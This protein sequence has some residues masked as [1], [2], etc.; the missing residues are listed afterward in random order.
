MQCTCHAALSVL[1]IEHCNATKHAIAYATPLAHL[2]CSCVQRPL[3]LF[4]TFASPEQSSTA[5][6]DTDNFQRS[7]AFKLSECAGATNDVLTSLVAA[8]DS[9]PSAMLTCLVPLP[10]RSSLRHYALVF[11]Q[12]A[13]K[14]NF[15]HGDL[16]GYAFS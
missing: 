14:V 4:C 6:L 15:H 3:P 5:A 11:L 16:G 8:F 2:L 1:A 12:G 9:D 13:V 10:L 7:H